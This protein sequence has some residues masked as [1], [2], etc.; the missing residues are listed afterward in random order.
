MAAR[1][2]SIDTTSASITDAHA[3]LISRII[4][5]KP[6]QIRYSADARDLE[7]RAAH[8]QAI[9]NALMAYLSEI[10]DDT[11]HN[12]NGI[13]RDVCRGISDDISDIVGSFTNAAESW[14]EDNCQFGVG[15]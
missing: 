10:V 6:H 12:A 11:A 2:D 4:T 5:N 15:A 13:D 8:I 7:D 9:G 3:H 14:R 1:A